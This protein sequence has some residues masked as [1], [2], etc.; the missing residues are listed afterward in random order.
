L[1][2]FNITGK[3]SSFKSAVGRRGTLND[4]ELTSTLIF[5][6]EDCA[7]NFKREE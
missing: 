7:G 6:R 3:V 2:I 1:Y 4:E 5:V